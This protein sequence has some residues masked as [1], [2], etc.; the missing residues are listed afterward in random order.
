MIR[1]ALPRF[2]RH[3]MFNEILPNMINEALPRFASHIMFNEKLLN[4]INEA[5][6]RLE[7][8][9]Q[10]YCGTAMIIEYIP[11]LLGLCHDF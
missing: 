5:L 1:E 10:V 7:S 11:Y 2:A 3:T 9:Y 6:P 8:H 4:M